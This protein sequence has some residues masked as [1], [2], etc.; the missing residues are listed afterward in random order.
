MIFQRVQ[1]ATLTEKQTEPAADRDC[2]TSV[3]N[4]ITVMC[5]PHHRD[6]TICWYEKS[7]PKARLT[8]RQ[9]SVEYFPPPAGLILSLIHIS[10]PTRH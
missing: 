1:H 6:E 5:L 4:D 9:R 8:I 10:E 7:G 2:R 3:K